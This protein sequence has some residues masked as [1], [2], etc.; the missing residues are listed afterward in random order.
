[1]AKVHRCIFKLPALFYCCHTLGTFVAKL[2]VLCAIFSSSSAR[3]FVKAL[4]AFMRGVTKPFLDLLR[5][6]MAVLINNRFVL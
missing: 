6:R 2:I 1:M 3:S 5:R 4:A